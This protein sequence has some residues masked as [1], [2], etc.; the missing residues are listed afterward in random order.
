MENPQREG[1][2]Q[3]DWGSGADP[4]SQ[5]WHQCADSALK[6][7]VGTGARTPS[8]KRDFSHLVLYQFLVQ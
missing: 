6:V 1:V 7:C 3:L 5:C 4:I 8:P 2:P